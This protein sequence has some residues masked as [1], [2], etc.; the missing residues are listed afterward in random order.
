MKNLSLVANTIRCLAADAVQKANSGHPGMPMGMADVAA[1]LFLKHL[2]HCPSRPDWINRDR[3]VLSGGHGSMLLY[4]LLHLSGYGLPME[5]LKS[6]RQWNSKTPGHPEVGHTPGVETTTGPLGQGCGNAV[7]MALAERMLAARLNIGS[8]VPIDHTTYVFCGDGDMMEGISHETL[9]LAGHLKLNRLIVFY[10]YN[11]I[12]IEGSTDLA[13]S[14]DV[15]KRFQGYHWNVLEIDGHNL[16]EIEKAVV[17]AK[18]EKE[19]PTLVLTHTH[20]AQGAPNLHDS[21]KA[22]GEPLGIEE[23]KATKRNL[24]FPEDQDFYV[25]EAVREL[26]AARTRELEA[27]VAAWDADLQKYR[28]GHP[29]RAAQWDIFFNHE[30]PADLLSQL[31]T[32]EVDKPIATRVASG[33]V[34]QKLAQLL[35]Y[36]VGGAADLAPSTRT[37]LEGYPSIKPGQY[38]GRNLH[39]GV[40]ELGMAAI[41]NGMTLHG[42]FRVFGA[43]FF[44]FSDYCRPSLRL[45]AIMKV[46]VI[47]VFTHD[48]FYVGEDGPTHEP[49]EHLM[50]LRMMPGLTIIRPADP[51]ETT[52]AWVAALKNT[53]GPTL[54]LL[55]RHNLPVLDRAV[56]PP[57][58]L[59]EKGAY[60]LWQSAPGKP[61]MLLIAT[62]SEVCLALAAARELAKEGVVRVVSMPCWEFFDR[63]PAAYRDEV[64]PPTCTLRLAIEAG[65]T[66][67]WQKYVGDRGQI[68]GIDHYGASAPFKVLAEKFGFV[69]AHVVEMVK[70]MLAAR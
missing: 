69:P 61:E 16:D 63:Q 68:L 65:T 35:P 60:T 13:Y 11:K 34:M 41:L 38:E 54:L 57:A 43:T 17:A 47:Y 10:D 52:A 50:S 49:I 40:R 51:T 59:L 53:G 25:P 55:T 12:T 58:N 20:I 46:P 36:L 28:A 19:R 18:A 32:F 21:H 6:F 39:F 67:G 22:H 44:V 37:F 1:V 62:G 45:S 3:F 2:N 24:G 30:L 29:D 14:D 5:E 26:F 56:Y 31:P 70:S 42:G 33:K 7:G 66:L 8:H 48:S 27:K 64:L 15:R 23:I 4:S 9:A